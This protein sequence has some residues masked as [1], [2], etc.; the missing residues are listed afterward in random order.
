MHLL[1]FLLFRQIARAGEFEVCGG[2][3]L[4][5]TGLARKLLVGRKT[6]GDGIAR[7]HDVVDAH[8]KP[9][10]VG[11]AVQILIDRYRFELDAVADDVDAGSGSLCPDH[12]VQ[13][14]DAGLDGFFTLYLKHLLAVFIVDI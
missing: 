11:F 8:V 9:A 4:R 14:I 12:T 13:T 5:A 3:P 1:L 2:E 10:H 6:V 7:D